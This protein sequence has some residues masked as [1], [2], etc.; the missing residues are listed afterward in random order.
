MNKESMPALIEEMANELKRVI[1]SRYPTQE[2][3]IIELKAHEKTVTVSFSVGNQRS[4]AI[5]MAVA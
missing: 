3:E 1:A 2:V 5:D 4:V